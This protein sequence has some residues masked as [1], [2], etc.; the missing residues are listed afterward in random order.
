MQNFIA[1]LKSYNASTHFIAIAALAMTAAFEGYPPFH[2]LV[3]STYAAMPTWVQVLIGTGGFIAALYKSGVLKVSS[4]G[5]SQ[6]LAVW[7]LI[8]LAL[9][10]T[11]PVAGCNVSTV[12]QDIVSWT[13]V[14]QGAVAVVDT[15]ASVL[16]P[17]AAPI[18]ALATGA[19]DTLSNQAVT[20]AKAYLAN[21]S[22]SL[23]VNLETQFA[24]FQ[25]TANSAL[26]QVA[27]IK[28]PTSQAKATADINAV[29]TCVNAML[30]LILSAKG[31][32]PVAALKLASA[33]FIQLKDVAGRIDWDQAAVTVANHYKEPVAWG[34]SKV[35]D[36]TGILF[37]YGF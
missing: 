15:T 29:L 24:T 33:N 28:D 20:Q 26:L 18:F 17:E 22:T 35:L 23:L 4:A 7:A 13:P 12:A 9:L 16:V 21:P 19:F 10:G 14:L 11:L 25:Q 36:G 8:S 6:K 27:G 31:A 5:N 37:A 1:W 34:Q 2:A 3:L 30:A 32:Q